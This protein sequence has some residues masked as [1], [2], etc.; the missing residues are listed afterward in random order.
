MFLSAGAIAIPGA[1]SEA[2]GHRRIMVGDRLRVSIKEQPDLN[3]VF[4]VAG[5]GS[6]AFPMIGRVMIANQT[7]DAAAQLIKTELEK[8]YFRQATVS[9]D[10]AEFVEGAIMVVGAVES[11]GAIPFKG[12]QLL[13]LV[14]AVILTGG[15]RADAAGNE[16]KILR[17]GEGG[18][19]EREVLTVD[20]RSMFNNLDFQ[21]D[22]FLRPRDIIMVPTLGQMEKGAKREF[23]VL[24]EV[25][26]PGFHA[27]AEGMDIIRVLTQVGGINNEAQMDAV[28]L[29][30]S[31]GHGNFTPIPIDL[32]RL[33][34]AADMSMNIAIQ[35]GDI[36]FVPSAQQATGGQIY[37]LGEVKSQGAINLPLNR[38]VTLA[39]T[40]LGAGGFGEYADAGNVKILRRAPDGTKQTLAVN[41]GKILKTGAFEDDVPL[42][43]GD[44][45]IVPESMLGF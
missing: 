45:I 27:F 16:V 10:V 37:L 41:V 14:E 3:Q 39:R 32:T 18:G 15:L 5:D 12:D 1:G 17:W 31:D 42:Q 8:S 33:L 22:Q 29:L 34:G 25:G 30:R 43:N 4:A 6:I 11:P 28:R 26:R 38:E 24:G 23:L 9:L 36:L 44:V 13:T 7:P 20:I 21:K 35:P 19:M 2:T 40:I